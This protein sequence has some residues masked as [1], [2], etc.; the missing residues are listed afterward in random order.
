[1]TTPNTGIPEVPE[2]TLDPAA[3]LNLSLQVLDAL[4]Q[5]AVISMAVSNPP[6]TPDDGALFIVAS[7]ATGAWAGEENNLARYVE[8]GDFWEFFDAGTQVKIVLNREDGLLYIFNEV[9]SPA[10]WQQLSGGGDAAQ[11]HGTLTAIAIASNIANMDHSLGADFSLELTSNVTTFNHNN[12][13]T[14]EANWF[15]MLLKQ[16]GVGSRTFAV[17]ASWTYGSGV[18]AYTVS[19]GANDVDLIQG[20]TYDDGVTWRI[21]YQKDFT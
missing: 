15:T 11:G 17:P 2:G 10:A 13:A 14:G 6:T 18:S 21:S 16:D 4:V 7:P 20:V 8:E 19:S 1:M 12:I 5:T 3:G 9:D